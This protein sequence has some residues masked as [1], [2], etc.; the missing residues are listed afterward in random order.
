MPTL[1]VTRVAHA[2]VL[3]AFGD[4]T[5]LTDPWFSERRGYYR[6]EPLGVA[7]ADL[8]PLTGVA[9]SHGHYDHY[10][11]AAF[12]AY[13]DKAVP[14]V[15][16]RGTVAAAHA[17]GFANV[18]ELDPWETAQ[19]GPI[20]VTAAP[21][22]HSVPQNTYI[23]QAGGRTVYFGG[24]TLLIPELAEVARR[25]PR[26]DLALLPINGLRIRPMLGR[27][28][29]MGPEDAAEL[30][31]LLRPRVAVPIHYRFT[32]GPLNDRMLLGYAGNPA[33]VCALHRGHSD[34]GAGNNGAGA[35]AR[36]TASDRREYGG[37]ADA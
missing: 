18:T 29:V 28:I 14:M 21:A 26:I 34:G 19:L 30:C 31:G 33:A 1:T 9:V 11:M 25:F 3:L 16:K 22:K 6:G 13:R 15:V 2:S 7:L 12:A 10:D 5:I 8:P 35:A 24:D 37:A 27:K 36:R 17:A 32:G 20:T 4:H 23:F